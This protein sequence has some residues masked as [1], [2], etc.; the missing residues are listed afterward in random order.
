[1]TRWVVATSINIII[2]T[3]NG[4]ALLNSDGSVNTL[5][6]FYMKI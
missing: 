3:S 5:G 1:M 4:N 6:K 2:L